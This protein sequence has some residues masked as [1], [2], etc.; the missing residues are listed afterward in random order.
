MTPQIFCLAKVDNSIEKFG[1]RG[2]RHARFCQR[3]N[4]HEI[5]LTSTGCLS[6]GTPE[7]W[8]IHVA[9]HSVEDA[10]YVYSCTCDVSY[11]DRIPPCYTRP[12]TALGMPVIHPCVNIQLYGA[13]RAQSCFRRDMLCSRMFFMKHEVWDRFETPAS[14]SI[15]SLV[16]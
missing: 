16:R 13:L 15:I 6:A 3:L 4:D 5:T 2:H 7:R 1:G 8:K 10:A 9:R 12:S 14:R 11:V